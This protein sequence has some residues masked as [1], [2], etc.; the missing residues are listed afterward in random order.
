MLAWFE[1]SV[2]ICCL[3]CEALGEGGGGCLATHRRGSFGPLFLHNQSEPRHG[4]HILRDL[5]ELATRCMS[6]VVHQ[7]LGWGAMA[8]DRELPA[9]SPQGPQ[10]L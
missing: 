7:M 1:G 4:T 5:V 3:E 10:G 2:E 9:P 6:W 8:P